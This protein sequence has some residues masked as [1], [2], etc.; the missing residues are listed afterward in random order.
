[1][2]HGNQHGAQGLRVVSCWNEAGLLAV[3][4]RIQ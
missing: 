2:P 4:N 1:M 3:E